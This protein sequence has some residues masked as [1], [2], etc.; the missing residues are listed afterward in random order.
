MEPLNN[1]T[2]SMINQTPLNQGNDSLPQKSLPKK[3]IIFGALGLIILI[4]TGL[5]VLFMQ[6]NQSNKNE[7]ILPSVT[8]LPTQPPSVEL[9]KAMD[10]AKASAEEYG[11][12]QD[13]VKND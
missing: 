6:R 5:G 13:D 3:T 8:P 2:Q 1:E 9:L 10:E 4:A 12:M 11:K 7:S